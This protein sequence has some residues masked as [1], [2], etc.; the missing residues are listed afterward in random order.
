MRYG[1]R[2]IIV[3]TSI[4]LCAPALAGDT[5]DRDALSRIEPQTMFQGMVREAD[6]EL[7]FDYLRRALLAVAEGR[8]APPSPELEDRAAQLGSELRLR[9]SMLGLA[10][11]NALEA[12]AQ[13]MLRQTPPPPHRHLPPP[14]SP[15][16]PVQD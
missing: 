8:E 6:L 9:G 4:G 12:E 11:L 5:V 14:T 10:L 16:I 2:T 3:A 13:A 7:F 1:V 15:L